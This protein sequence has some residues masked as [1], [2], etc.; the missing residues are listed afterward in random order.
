M[1]ISPPPEE[2]RLRHSRFAELCRETVRQTRE[3][4]FDVDDLL[5]ELAEFRGMERDTPS[6][7]PYR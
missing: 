3:L 7:G 6:P 1:S 2:E 5:E 4:G